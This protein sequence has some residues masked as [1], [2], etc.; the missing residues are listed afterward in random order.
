MRR[1][2]P[3]GRIGI[4]GGGQL[5]RMMALAARSMGYRVEALDPDASCSARGVVDHCYTTAFSDVGAA[6]TMARESDVVTLEIEKIPLATLNAVARVAPLRPGAGVLEIIQHRGRQ[7]AWLARAGA[8]LG[9]WLEAHDPLALEGAVRQLGGRCFVKSCEGGYDG[10]GQ[11]ETA[12]AG[13]ARAAWDQ[14]GGRAVVAE[15]ALPLAAEVSVLVARSPSGEIAV[16]PPALNHHE[17]RVLAW[18]TFPGSM[19]VR[20]VREAEAAARAIAE[21]LELEGVLAVEM[22]VLEDG[23]LRVNELAPR[24]HNSFHATEEGCVTSQFEQAIRAVCNLPLGSVE[25]VRPAAIM[26]LLGERWAR[27][28][29]HFERA[30]ELPGVKVHLYGK[31]EARP[32]RKMGHLSAVRRTSEE[33]LALAKEASKRLADEAA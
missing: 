10:R 11:V 29:P 26:N 15:A 30:L 3:G 16:Y 24:P 28:A 18:S 14:L 20:L 17:A 12:S 2:L 21:Q 31:S 6:E 19:E 4:L 32:G 5:G 25:V 1:V 8:P 22:F 33:A 9:A 13:E 23:S 27:G 7:R